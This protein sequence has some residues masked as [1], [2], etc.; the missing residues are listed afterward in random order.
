MG[1]TKTRE[2]QVASVADQQ[3]GEMFVLDAQHHVTEHLEAEEG[4]EGV[5]NA[6]MKNIN[7]GASKGNAEAGRRQVCKG[8]GVQ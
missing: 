4:E 5:G 8:R 3:V 2:Q 7:A 1:T 6:V